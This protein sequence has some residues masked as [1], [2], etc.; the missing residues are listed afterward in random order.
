MALTGAEKALKERVEFC[1]SFEEL[2]ILREI[3]MRRCKPVTK[4]DTPKIVVGNKKNF[5]ST[6]FPQWWY[7]TS[8][9][10]TNTEEGGAFDGEILDVLNNPNDATYLKRDVVFGHFNFSLKQGSLRLCASQIEGKQ[11]V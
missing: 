9:Q 6:W 3:A 8:L 7:S 2:R 1:Q 11:P 5:I 4:A 10:Y